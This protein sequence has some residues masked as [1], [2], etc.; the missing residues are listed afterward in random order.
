MRER[1][2]RR[3]GNRDSG[4]RDGALREEVDDGLPAAKPQHE[5]ES[6]RSVDVVVGQRTAILKLSPR[7]YE[8]LLILRDPFYIMYLAFDVVDGVGGLASDQE[9]FA[10]PPDR[11]VPHCQRPSGHII[12]TLRAIDERKFTYVSI[13]TNIPSG[14]PVT[15]AGARR[16]GSLYAGGASKQMCS[17]AS[18]GVLKPRGGSEV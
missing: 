8:A 18:G 2:L 5:V 6:T 12:A 15:W 1:P 14:V 10:G 9:R 7:E 17:V 4:V 13:R 11:V 3:E 16:D